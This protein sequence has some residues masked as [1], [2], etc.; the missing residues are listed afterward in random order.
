MSGKNIIILLMY[1]RHKLLDLNNILSKRIE[2]LCR[3]HNVTRPA[4]AVE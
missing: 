4:V 2:R 3:P 1:H